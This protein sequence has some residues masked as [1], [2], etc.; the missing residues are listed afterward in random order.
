MSSL[1]QDDIC[2][3]PKIVQVLPFGRK[4]LTLNSGT[5]MDIPKVIRKVLP[6]RLIKQYNQ[7]GGL[8]FTLSPIL[9]EACVT[10]VRKSLFGLYSNAAEEGL[11]FDDL[12]SLFDALAQYVANEAEDLRCLKQYTKSDYKVKEY[13]QAVLLF[14]KG[15]TALNDSKN[16]RY[17]RQCDHQHN[18]LFGSCETL[19]TST[20]LPQDLQEELNPLLKDS[21]AANSPPGYCKDGYCR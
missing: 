19:K 5:R 18:Q 1:R 13:F 4:T 16:E 3:S 12:L 10:S 14:S 20:N 6:S 21:S 7:R 11:G 2:M 15:V 9:S 17:P 8:R